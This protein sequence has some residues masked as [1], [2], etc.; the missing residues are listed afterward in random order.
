[1]AK[2]EREVEI[3]AP[4]Q[5]AWAVLTDATLWPKWF[6]FMHSVSNVRPLAEGAVINWNSGDQDGIA[7]ITKFVPEKELEILTNLEGNEDKHNFTLRSSGGFFGLKADEAKVEY[8]LDTMTGG[9][10]L[11]R[12]V[13][14]GNPRDM[15]RVKNATNA[16]RRLVETHYPHA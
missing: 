2:F 5:N 10:I 15:L 7:T 8:K 13:T 9:G 11:G 14:G 4:V 12:F 1:M 3:D 6:P 16:L